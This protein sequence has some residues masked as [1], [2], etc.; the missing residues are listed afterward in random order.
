M[1]QPSAAREVT[2]ERSWQFN[3]R[4]KELVEAGWVRVEE[5]VQRIMIG[6]NRWRGTDLLPGQLFGRTEDSMI[7]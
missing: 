7:L 6:T 3:M 5:P 2:Q 1:V 4:S